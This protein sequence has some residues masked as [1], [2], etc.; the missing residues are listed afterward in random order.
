[1]PRGGSGTHVRRRRRC[2]GGRPAVR[3]CAALGGRV[4]GRHVLRLQG[5]LRGLARVGGRLVQRPRRQVLLLRGH[6]GLGAARHRG[7][8]PQLRRRLRR[9]LGREVRRQ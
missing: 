8:A 7:L 9:C 4:R 2:C 3:R 6:G 5:V 1:M